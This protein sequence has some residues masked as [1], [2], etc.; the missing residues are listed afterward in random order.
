MSSENEERAMEEM[1][2]LTSCVCGYISNE[3]RAR[4]IFYPFHIPFLGPFFSLLFCPNHDAEDAIYI[5]EKKFWL[6]GVHKFIALTSI[7]QQSCI[8]TCVYAE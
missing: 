6:L 1:I 7:I 4:D 3:S 8:S 2:M 5:R